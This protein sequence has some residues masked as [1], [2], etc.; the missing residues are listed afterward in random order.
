[1]VEGGA[2]GME[3]GEDLFLDV[4]LSFYGRDNC[5][6]VWRTVELGMVVWILSKA[7]ICC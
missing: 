5:D 6:L 3:I 2:I 1:M 4:G 7:I